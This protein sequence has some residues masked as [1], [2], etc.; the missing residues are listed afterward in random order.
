MRLR[1]GW[2]NVRHALLH[3]EWKRVRLLLVST[4]FGSISSF[5]EMEPESTRRTGVVFL[6]GPQQPHH[7]A[8]TCFAIYTISKL[9]HTRPFSVCFGTEV[10]ERTDEGF[11]FPRVVAAFCS[12]AQFAIWLQGMRC[13]YGKFS[14]PGECWFE[15]RGFWS[16]ERQAKARGHFRCGRRNTCRVTKS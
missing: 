2:F 12:G 15:R 14:S 1:F 3:D 8:K 16:C 5:L 11:E 13:F 7:R 4:A 9:V 10:R 6:S